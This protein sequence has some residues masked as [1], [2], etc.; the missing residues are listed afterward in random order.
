M[1][2]IKITFEAP[3]RTALDNALR[4]FLG[5]DPVHHAVPQTAALVKLNTLATPEKPISVAATV[6][7]AGKQEQAPKD[8]PAAAA[9]SQKPDESQ[10]AGETLAE[11]SYDDLKKSIMKLVAIDPKHMREIADSFGVK[12]FQ[13]TTADVWPKA[14][15]AVDD[16]IVAL[17]G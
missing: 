10:A 13:G 3:T 7:P 4:D 17:R 5:Q 11:V 16:K 2:M 14:K 15:K 8:E 9:S 12:T 1:K 6:T